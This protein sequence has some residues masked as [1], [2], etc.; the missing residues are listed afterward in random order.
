MKKWLIVVAILICLGL[1]AIVKFSM[2]QDQ[3]ISNQVEQSQTS[4]QISNSSNAGNAD[5]PAPAE[6]SEPA[7]PADQ[8]EAIVK[9][10]N[11]FKDALKNKNYEKAWEHTSKYFKQRD[12]G[13]NFEQ[14]RD[15]MIAKE[16]IFAQAIIHP[17]TAFKT[18]LNNEDVVG[19]LYTGP[20][21]N[22]DLYLFFIQEDDQWKLYIGKEASEVTR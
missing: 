9:V 5:K 12:S 11:E 8:V 7:V 1:Y 6:D 13:G 3:D 16:S 10:Y 20:S 14:F 17:D 2:S 19:F 15:N 4:E 18:A 21:F 22:V